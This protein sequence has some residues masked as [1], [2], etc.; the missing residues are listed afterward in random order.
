MIKRDDIPLA[1]TC[2]A[3]GNEL[4]FKNSDGFWREYT[5]DANGRVLTRKDSDGYWY[6]YTYDDHGNELT[7]KNSDGFWYE[8]TRDA[9]GNELTSKSGRIDPDAEP[10]STDS[11]LLTSI[12]DLLDHSLTDG[13]SVINKADGEPTALILYPE[14][15][16]A[17]SVQEAH[18]LISAGRLFRFDEQ[19]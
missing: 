18:D 17:M 8:S 3:N 6:E 5:R 13:L 16:R 4:T 9:N 12:Q 7:Y 15:V 11:S 14:A 19:V 10:A 2:D 1:Y